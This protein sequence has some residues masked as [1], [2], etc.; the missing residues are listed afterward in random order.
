[1]A[2]IVCLSGFAIL[3]IITK[4]CHPR[5]SQVHL[6]SNLHK[7]SQSQST[8][9]PDG[10]TSLSSEDFRG[11][12]FLLVSLLHGSL[13]FSLVDN[14]LTRGEFTQPLFWT[15]AF[16]NLSVFFRV[17]QS[18]LA[19]ALKYDRYWKLKPFDFASVFLA[20]LLEY[21][22]FCHDKYP[23]GRGQFRP[24]LLTIF[25]MFGVLSYIGSLSRVKKQLSTEDLSAEMKIQILNV[26]AMI[27]CALACVLHLVVPM[28]IPLWALEAL[29]G[30]VLMLNLS[31]SMR[32]LI[33]SPLLD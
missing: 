5:R 32:Q 12:F 3:A 2:V 30:C 1:M 27:F 17:L 15:T 9:S 29:L 14:L 7:K 16:L 19:A 26:V 25:C 23:W 20:V 22:L 4:C 21:L 28:T 24:T 13:F 11:L 31:A 8:S 18:Q 6:T 33:N 10:R